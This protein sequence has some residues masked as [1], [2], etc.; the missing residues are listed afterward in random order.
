MDTPLGRPGGTEPGQAGREP[1]D[2]E[3]APH[4]D[5]WRGWLLVV[6]ALVLLA[7]LVPPL[8]VLA[9]EHVSTEALQF[10]L[11]AYAAPALVALGLPTA[12]RSR[13]AGVPL[14]ARA[15]ARRSAVAGPGQRRPMRRPRSVVV[16]VAFA[17]VALLWRTPIAVNALQGEAWVAVIEAA[18]LLVA[19]TALWVELTDNSAATATLNGPMRMAMAALSMW[20][21]W[22]VA[23][24]LGF[25]DVPWYRSFHHSPGGLSL[26]ADQQIACWILWAVPGLAFVP[27]VFQ[28]LVAWLRQEER[29]SS[30]S[31]RPPAAGATA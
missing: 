27:V 8:G 28:R 15:V 18:S 22:I 30:G 25:S 31:P 5:A 2:P 6:A 16:L 9:R 14:G 12:T 19:G 11:L 3:T 23:Y 10:A 21:I 7:C 13:L 17:A 26:A 29:G 1:G 20:S 24:M 4:A